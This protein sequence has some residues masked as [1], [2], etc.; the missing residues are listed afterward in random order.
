MEVRENPDSVTAIFE[1]GTTCEGR[2]IVGCDGSA[3]RVRK[4]V[5][6]TTYENQTVPV[7]FVGATVRYTPEQIR[8]ALALDPYFFQGT[9]PETNVY[10]YFSGK[11]SGNPGSLDPYLLNFASLVLNTPRNIGN[12]TDYY[13]AQAVVTWSYDKNIEIP[14][15]DAETVA[16]IKQL[17]SNWASPFRELI[18]AIPED[19]EIRRIHIS[20]WYPTTSREHERVVVMGDAA[21]SMTMC[22]YKIMN[23]EDGRS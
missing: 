2:L 8:P 10:L 20:D 6:P 9:H 11:C 15:N 22:E 4:Y 23:Y 17:T 12:D 19:A 13:V 16:L 18:E 14:E 5:Y 7:H 3:S 1:D 21:H